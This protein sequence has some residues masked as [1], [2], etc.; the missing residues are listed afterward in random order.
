MQEVYLTET[1][2]YR[3]KLAFQKPLG[4]IKALP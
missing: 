1:E 3:K 4:I 2:V